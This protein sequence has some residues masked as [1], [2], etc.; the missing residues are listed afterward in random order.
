MP[1]QNRQSKRG[2]GQAAALALT[3]VVLW[4]A[5]WYFRM[6]PAGSQAM[7]AAAPPSASAAT[8][9]PQAGVAGSGASGAARAAG[10]AGARD[11]A[12]D[13]DGGRDGG[14][15]GGG[16]EALGAADAGADALA[17][18]AAAEPGDAG[19]APKPADVTACVAGLFPPSS[20]DRA[21]ADLSFVCEER[22][23]R[24]G[25]TKIQSQVAL[26][27]WGQGGATEG[28]REWAIMGWYEL[29][30]LATF[31]GHCCAEPPAMIWTFKLACP[32]DQAMVDLEGAVRARDTKAMA[33]A[34]GDYTRAARCLSKL[35]QGRNFGQ[36]GVPGAGLMT[37]EKTLRR[38]RAAW[39]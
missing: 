7:P 34:V 20:F 19:S 6:A 28:M 16:G 32:L 12:A 26:D 17:T 31:R 36:K 9:G 23:P 8:A 18:D 37:F 22:Y 38:V 25:I 35:G 24:Q 27:K 33:A 13:R 1:T 29:A 4:G 15:G 39:K 5:G 14:A 21:N 30:A 11:A 3:A 2:R 10:G